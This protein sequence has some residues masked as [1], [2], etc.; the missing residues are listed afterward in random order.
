MNIVS[1]ES[2]NNKDLLFQRFLSK[3]ILAIKEIFD[4]CFTESIYFEQTSKLSSNG[5]KFMHKLYIEEKCNKKDILMK[6][7]DFMEYTDT[8]EI[9]SK[10]NLSN[11]VSDGMIR[12]IF[13]MMY[14]G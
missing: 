6:S 4:S 5:G 14:R 9:T 8:Y 7:I 2:K 13:E 3:D 12:E 10:N 11:K 1:N